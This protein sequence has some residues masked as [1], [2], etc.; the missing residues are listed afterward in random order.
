MRGTALPLLAQRLLAL[1]HP[2][3]TLWTACALAAAGALVV[4]A[5]WSVESLAAGVVVAGSAAGAA[6]P[7]LVTAVA[8]TVPAAGADRA[9]AVV[10]S[11]TGVGVVAGGL[12]AAALLDQWRPLWAGFAVAAVLAA[13]W[14]D[15]RASWPPAPTAVRSGARGP[16]GELALRRHLFAAL[17]AGAGSAAVWTF[18]RDL[19][20]TTGG[21]PA[22]TTAL[23]W[24]VLG[25]AG[26]AGALSGDLVRRLGLR[27][28]WVVTA[29]VMAAATAVLAVRP[30]HVPL[31]ATALAAFGGSYVALSGVLIACATRATPHRAAGSTAALFIALTAGQALGAAGLGALAGATTPGTGFLG[32]A[33]LILLS[34]LVVI[35]PARH[36]PARR[37][38]AAPPAPA[39]VLHR[40]A[41]QRPERSTEGA[42]ERGDPVLDGHRGGL[43]AVEGLSPAARSTTRRR[44][45]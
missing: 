44:G 43:D 27:L 29:V 13:W 17:L 37:D 38:P 9:Q 35:S 31:A 24:C 30:D 3:A 39:P 12:L 14:A 34:S 8:T 6:S 42:P 45:T 19:L 15:R 26:A 2:R 28:A 18:G 5:S 32:G 11:G 16:W 36:R 25:G 1:G 41:A 22:A 21:V 23:L 4:C 33:A 7:A 20:T 40:P 10:N